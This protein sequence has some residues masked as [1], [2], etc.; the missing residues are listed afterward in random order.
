MPAKKKEKKKS[1]SG[2][3]SR[4]EGLISEPE[5]CFTPGVPDDGFSML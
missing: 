2:S 1:V 4:V 3:R 5:H